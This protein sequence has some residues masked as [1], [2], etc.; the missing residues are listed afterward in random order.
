MVDDEDVVRDMMSRSLT[1]KGFEVVAANG[2]AEALKCT[3]ATSFDEATRII[4]DWRQKYN[5]S[6]PRS[7]GKRNLASWPVN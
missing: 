3:A 5:E 4:E 6:T 1:S 2:V 7:L